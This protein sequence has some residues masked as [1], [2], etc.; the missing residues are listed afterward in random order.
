MEP[1]LT[2]L[3]SQSL[4]NTDLPLKELQALFEEILGIGETILSM[5][6]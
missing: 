4:K 1:R 3:A 5:M 6:N 2:L